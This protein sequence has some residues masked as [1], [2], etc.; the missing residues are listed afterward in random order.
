MYILN[1]SSRSQHEIVTT[2]GVVSSLTLVDK[3]KTKRNGDES[4]I[5]LNI[6]N[7]I[8]LPYTDYKRFIL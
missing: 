2:R 5:K 6:D 4:Y 8:I 1:I 3:A 7:L